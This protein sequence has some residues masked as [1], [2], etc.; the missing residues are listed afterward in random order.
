LP[1]REILEAIKGCVY[2]I[3]EINLMTGR[4]IDATFS[5]DFEDLRSNWFA[6][7]REAAVRRLTEIFR[8][9]L[10]ISFEAAFSLGGWLGKYSQLKPA[11]DLKIR[12]TSFWHQTRLDK[13]ARNIYLNTFGERRVFSDAV[14]TPEQALELSI[15]S[16]K[17][18]KI[19]L[20]PISRVIDFY[21]IFQPFSMASMLL[22]LADETGLLSDNLKKD[23]F[24]NQESVS[25]FKPEVIQKRNKIINE[26]TET[27]N[28]KQ[29]IGL[30]CKGW[31][32]SGRFG[33][34]FEQ[35]SLKRKFVTFLLKRK[36]WQIINQI[37]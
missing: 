21:I 31:L 30:G 18:L 16:C 2:I 34:L 19:G 17:K 35:E 36:F 12:K 3:R 32:F 37:Q 27:Y 26:I 33:Y 13:R 8:R 7:D 11:K 5:K 9:G 24:T 14:K 4:E 23:I 1:V 6:L 20:G 25:V 29:V 10:L 15:G 22:G 28:K